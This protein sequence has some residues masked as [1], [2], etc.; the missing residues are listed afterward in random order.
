MINFLIRKLLIQLSLPLGLSL[1][2]SIYGIFKNKKKYI[3]SSIFLLYFASIN[4]FSELLFK[5]VEYPS[6]YQK[7]INGRT[8]VVLSGGILKS[9]NI[10]NGIYEWNDP[11]RFF[12]GI[13]LYKMNKSRDLVFT[14]GLNPYEYNGKSEGQLLKE[15]SKNFI[16]DAENIIVSG[17]AQNTFEESKQIKKLIINEKIKNNVILVTSAFHMN[18]ALLIFKKEGI[19]VTPY[20]V[21]FKSSNLSIFRILKNPLNWI[22]NANSLTKSSLAVKEIY[23]ILFYKLI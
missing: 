23:G 2:L 12:A 8:I 21:D 9:N 3:L 13:N 6:K 17:L 5:V 10:K 22:P 16:S 1:I 20:P 18:R 4:V 19:K 11:D 14:G 15:Q 7:N